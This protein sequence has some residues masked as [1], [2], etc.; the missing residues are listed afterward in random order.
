MSKI[1]ANA[2]N[3]NLAAP[4]GAQPTAAPVNCIPLTPEE[5][6][7]HIAQARDELRLPTVA[8][9]IL[10]DLYRWR[11][12]RRM[13]VAVSW[14]D[15]TLGLVNPAGMFDVPYDPLL[16]MLTDPAVF[17]Y[18]TASGDESSGSFN[19]NI[20]AAAG[21]FY[22]V[23]ALQLSL[24]PDPDQ[25][26]VRNGRWIS[27]I[28]LEHQTIDG[29]SN[30]EDGN[31]GVTTWGDVVDATNDVRFDHPSGESVGGI[32]LH[33]ASRPAGL[34]VTQPTRAILASPVDSGVHG[35]HTIANAFTNLGSGSGIGGVVTVL[36]P[37]TPEFVR[38]AQRMLRA[39]YER[40]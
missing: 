15:T 40:V 34:P 14:G 36:H 29:V 23:R 27:T 19:A 8:G 37:G 24:N 4:T 26:G 11:P 1:P 17:A 10:L 2:F 13:P 38:Y 21:T 9:D 22:R 25:K 20:A 16:S 7:E 18:L 31:S 33:F 5:R 30:T 32:F 3:H 28:N 35:A 6:R 12:C 39:F